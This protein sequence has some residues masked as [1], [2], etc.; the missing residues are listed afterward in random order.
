MYR[1][2]ICALLDFFHASRSHP[3]W[4]YNPSF[5]TLQLV[6]VQMNMFSQEQIVT[7]RGARTD[8]RHRK[9]MSTQQARTGTLPQ[10]PSVRHKGRKK[11]TQ[12][13]KENGIKGEV[14]YSKRNLESSSWG[15]VSY[16]IVCIIQYINFLNFHSQS[17]ISK[18]D[19]CSL[20]LN[21]LPLLFLYTQL[22]FQQNCSTTFCSYLYF[23]TITY[24]N[25]TTWNVYAQ[26]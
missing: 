26:P 18:E 1:N 17:R 3:N 5:F 16:F 15:D 13:K 23:Y 11:Q 22:I 25:L 6:I 21:F 8:I 10:M 19:P 24:I 7:L 2:R 14:N 20:S 4:C 12:R 9:Q